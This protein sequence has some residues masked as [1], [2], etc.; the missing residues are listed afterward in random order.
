VLKG[1]RRAVIRSVRAVSIHGQL[2]FDVRFVDA[3]DVEGVEHVARVGAES[4]PR[5]L[6]P[7]DRVEIDYLVG[8]V[9]GVRR[10]V[11]S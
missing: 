4:A 6:S 3:D 7:G 11:D 2:S 8:V 1:S 10:L 9:T 5:V